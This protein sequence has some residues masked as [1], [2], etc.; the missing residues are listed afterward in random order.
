MYFFDNFI[1]SHNR[2]PVIGL[3]IDGDLDT[4]KIILE[5]LT[6][7]PPVPVVVCDGSGG[8]SDLIAFVYKY[9]FDNDNEIAIKSIKDYLLT[10]IQRNF[11]VN[12][13]QSE[14]VFDDLIKCAK[15]KSLVSF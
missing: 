12:V 7:T 1:A 2:I 11:S 10:T 5:Y 6:L 8:I 9:T 15:H 3:I 4:L 13:E 14:T